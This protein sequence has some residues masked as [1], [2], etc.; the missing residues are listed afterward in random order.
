METAPK[1]GTEFLALQEGEIY[2]T[3]FEANHP[4]RLCF[5]TH[6]L[7]VHEKHRAIKAIMDG[8]EVSAH[9][10]I[11]K[12]WPETFRHDWTLWTRGFEFAPTAWAPLP[13]T[14]S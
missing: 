1:G 14:S 6:H 7:F 3:K 13:E 11:D 2:H 5:R 9:V 10:A 8:Q 12:P 4:F